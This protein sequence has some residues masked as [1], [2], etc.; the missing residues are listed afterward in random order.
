MLIKNNIFKSSKR[1][2]M[3]SNL[4]SRHSLANEQLW[5][6]SILVNFLF[7]FKLPEFLSD[8]RLPDVFEVWQTDFFSGI[9]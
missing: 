7:D 4:S 6:E 8:A 3:L 1:E 5:L 2:W 9:L